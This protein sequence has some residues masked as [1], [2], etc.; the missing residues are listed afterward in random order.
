MGNSPALNAA[1]AKSMKPLYEKYAGNLTVIGVYVE[2]LMNLNAWKLWQ[3]NT[4]TG[5]FW[6]LLWV[7]VGVVW[8]VRWVWWVL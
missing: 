8:W 4:T 7:G 2:G 6:Y 5:E 3:K 1:F